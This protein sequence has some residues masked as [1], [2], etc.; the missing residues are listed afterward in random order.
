MADRGRDT[1][2]E[3]TEVRTVLSRAETALEYLHMLR[4][5][6]FKDPDAAEMRV[7]LFEVVEK[8]SRW[9]RTG[10]PLKGG[11]ND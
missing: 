4:D 6:G 7:A 10:R 11:R 1:S 2:R 8:L 9:R 3:L 5:R